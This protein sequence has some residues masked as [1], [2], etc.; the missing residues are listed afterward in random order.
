MRTRV[1]ITIDTEFNI[2]GAFSDTT[3]VPVAEQNVWCNVD[4]RS[5]GLGFMLDTFRQNQVQATFFVETVQRYYFKHDPMGAIA[6]QVLDAGHEV[7]LHTHPCWSLFKHNDWRERVRD[8]RRPDDFQGRSLD[9]S[10]ALLQQ[11]ID[12][13]R[14][15]GLPRP[16]AFRSGN[17][18]HDDNL[19]RALAEVGIPYS[20]N[21]GVGVYDTG[22]PDYALYSGTHE[23]FGVLE[24]PVLSY[25][26]WQ[27]GSHQ[28]MKSLTIAG[29]SF[30]EMRSLLEQAHAAQVPLV[31]ILTH[32]FEYVQTTD[33]DYVHA[34]RHGVTQQR[35][36][37]L[38]AFLHANQDR[39][40]A[41][42]MVSAIESPACRD[43]RNLLLKS[44]L[45]YSVPR[46]GTQVVYDY[47]G[48]LAL[49][50][51]KPVPS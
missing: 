14:D 35:L 19:F 7:E 37:K 9:D 21:V 6:R 50:C 26:D 13:F 51:T 24:C 12:T 11:G 41:S 44:P 8:Q 18:Q 28:H 2:G 43:G 17:L 16:R 40:D 1:C 39:F 45:W 34:R 22:N 46:M 20:S 36:A 15:W 47:F 3:R 5:E 27:L 29:T 33:D 38:C 49:A 32:P 10:I 48:S 4:G 30:S 31:V 42:G 23:R 25:T